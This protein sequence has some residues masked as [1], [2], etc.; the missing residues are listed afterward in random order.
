[1]DNGEVLERARRKVAQGRATD[2][3]GEEMDAYRQWSKPRSEAH[4]EAIQRTQEEARR[5]FTEQERDIFSFI[6]R[7]FNRLAANE[8]YDRDKHDDLVLSKASER[9]GVTKEEAKRIFV[10]VDGA[11]LGLA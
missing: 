1:M 4:A 6:R 2:M 9:F 7:E 8:G 3:T 11:G 5:S 10:E